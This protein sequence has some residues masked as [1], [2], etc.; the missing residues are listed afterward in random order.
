M[1]APVYGGPPIPPRRFWRRWMLWAIGILI[2][3]VAWLLFS[4]RVWPPMPVYGGPPIHAPQPP[5]V[6]MA[7]Q[8]IRDKLV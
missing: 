2:A 3:I 6:L 7:L 5:A 8:R 1:P 4:H